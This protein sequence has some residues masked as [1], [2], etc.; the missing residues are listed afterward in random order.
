MQRRLVGPIYSASNLQKHEHLIEA[1][2]ER[3]VAKLRTMNGEEVDLTDWM[4]I[5]AVESLTAVT[6]DWS[7]GL[8]ED[9]SD[10]GTFMDGYFQFWRFFTVVGLYP[11][12]VLIAHKL[13]VSAK[14]FLQRVV[15]TGV[16]ASPTPPKNIWIVSIT[17]FRTSRSEHSTANFLVPFSPR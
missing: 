2:I 6:F 14:R 8:I 16:A 4:H 11:Y 17:S 15:Q 10:H 3:F 5:L 7:P 9:G 1:V 13:G 12:A